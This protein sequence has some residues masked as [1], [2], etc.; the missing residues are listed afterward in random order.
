MSSK[1]QWLGVFLGALFLLLSSS[2]LRSSVA[3]AQKRIVVL[4]IEGSRSDGLRDSITRLIR[5][6]KSLNDN[7]YRNAARRLRAPKLNPKSVAKVARYLEAD[8][9]IDGMLVARMVRTN[10]PCGSARDV[11]APSC[12]P[13]P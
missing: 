5:P 3:S 10:S 13:F 12:R 9:I 6:H 11:T 1:S 2:V 8:G 7:T 4:E